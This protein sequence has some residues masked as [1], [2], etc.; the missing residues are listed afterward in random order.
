MIG[1]LCPGCTVGFL[2]I[3]TIW[4]GALMTNS[5]IKNI[6]GRAIE[7]YFREYSE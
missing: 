5:L 2:I 1:V 4:R 3:E 7:I 6:A